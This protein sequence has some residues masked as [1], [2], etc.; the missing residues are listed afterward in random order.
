[1]EAGF[2]FV[3]RGKEWSIAE[4]TDGHLFYMCGVEVSFEEWEFD[5]IIK[6]EM[7]K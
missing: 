1:M 4:Y 5:E 7:P 3:K 2:Y 6:I